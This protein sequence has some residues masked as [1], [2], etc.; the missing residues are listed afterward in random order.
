MHVYLL[1]SL[2]G[3]R[4]ETFPNLVPREWFFNFFSLLKWPVWEG[5]VLEAVFHVPFGNSQRQDGA[6]LSAGG[7]SFMI[8]EAML[9]RK[10]NQ[11]IPEQ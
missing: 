4:S 11:G 3:E 10:S 6:G 5:C 2:F 9:N 1:L 7:K 8:N